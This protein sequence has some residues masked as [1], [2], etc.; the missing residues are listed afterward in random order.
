MGSHTADSG[1]DSDTGVERVATMTATTAASP[2]ACMRRQRAVRAGSSVV[3]A[4]MK[5]SGRSSGWARAGGDIVPG[6]PAVASH[7][8]WQL[9]SFRTSEKVWGIVGV[10]LLSQ[11]CWWDALCTRV[12][13]E[14]GR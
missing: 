12:R 11:C 2:F 1:R 13:V 14:G 9:A 7:S 4:V 10:L 6:A 8:L 5:Q 3:V